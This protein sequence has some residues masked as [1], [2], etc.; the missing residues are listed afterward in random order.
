MKKF[1][2]DQIKKTLNY[3]L[4]VLADLEDQYTNSAFGVDRLVLANELGLKVIPTLNDLNNNII[5]E[6]KMTYV[7]ENKITKNIKKRLEAITLNL[8]KS[9]LDENDR[10][11]LL[12]ELTILTEQLT[13]LTD[14]KTSEKELLLG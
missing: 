13:K 1:K 5:G 10:D 6:N 11:H 3:V 4:Q 8:K 9:D 14:V 2:L 7:D 12:T